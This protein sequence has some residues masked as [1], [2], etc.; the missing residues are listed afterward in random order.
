M[1]FSFSN[2]RYKIIHGDVPSVDTNLSPE[3]KRISQELSV[4]PEIFAILTS[5]L[6]LA[7]FIELQ[8]LYDTE[9]VY[10]M[11]EILDAHHTISVENQKRANK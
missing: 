9:D 6:K 2:A 4:L 10:D 8:T 5:D 7:T 3:L 11:L 1:W